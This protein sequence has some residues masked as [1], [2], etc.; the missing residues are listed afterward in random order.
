MIDA[1]ALQDKMQYAVIRLGPKLIHLVDSQEEE[2]GI[3]LHTEQRPC[4]HRG[5][6]RI[7]MAERGLQR[8]NADVRLQGSRMTAADVAT[9]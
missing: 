1:N 6:S 3:Q 8:A 2:I 4:E 9:V 7:C 5:Q